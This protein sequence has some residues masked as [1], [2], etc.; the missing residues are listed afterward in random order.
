MYVIIGINLIVGFF[1]GIAWEA[2][3]GGLIVG[4]AVG[5]LLI[6]TR[7]SAKKN[8]QLLGLV[9]IGIALVAIWIIGNAPINVLNN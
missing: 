9:G 2:H 4:A 3:V 6:S 5:Y 8:L 1:P 7:D